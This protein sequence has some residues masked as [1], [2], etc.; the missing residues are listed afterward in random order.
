MTMRDPGHAAKATSK[1]MIQSSS[2]TVWR[3]GD[4]PSMGTAA[5]AC[6][7]VGS[8]VHVHFMFSIEL[9]AE[10]T[11]LPSHNCPIPSNLLFS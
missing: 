5:T 10:T 4:D 9:M 6:T 2:S 3:R 1:A 11:P 7:A 8:N